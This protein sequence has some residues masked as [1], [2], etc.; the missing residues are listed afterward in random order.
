MLAGAPVVG[1]LSR[2]GLVMGVVVV[3]NAILI[4]GKCV[5]ARQEGQKE[6]GGGGGGYSCTRVASQG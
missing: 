4:L 2:V 6:R 1:D 5:T 3:T